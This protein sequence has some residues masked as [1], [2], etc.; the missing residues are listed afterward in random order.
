VSLVAVDLFSG[1]GGATEYMYRRGKDAW[2]VYRYDNDERFTKVPCTQIVDVLELTATDLPKH[3]DLLWAS[4]PCN[5]W[6]PGTI[7]RYWSY[8]NGVQPEAYENLILIAHVLKIIGESHPKFWW[9]EN[10][11]GKMRSAGLGPP[12]ISFPL[13]TY[14]TRGKKPTDFWGYMPKNLKIPKI[15]RGWEA[16]PRGAKTGTQGI[17]DR[18]ERALIPYALSMAIG[19]AIEEALDIANIPT[20]LEI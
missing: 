8:K 13:A 15:K 10:P 5:V 17:K 16:A 9:I 3:I 12:T 11:I 7:G 2:K 18:A 1:L 20:M 19:T 6:S 4:P 14:G